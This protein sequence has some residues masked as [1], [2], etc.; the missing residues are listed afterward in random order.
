MF[1]TLHQIFRCWA[2]Y[3]KSWRIIVLPFLLLLYNV[4]TVIMMTYWNVT[5]PGAVSTSFG[6]RLQG[7]QG[8]YFASTILI[9]IYSTCVW[10]NFAFH[11]LILSKFE[12]AIIVKIWRNTLSRHL[13]RFTIRVV[14]ESGLLY[15]ISSIVTFCMV[16]L[17]TPGSIMIA[18]AI[19]RCQRF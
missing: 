9:N 16:F 1:L 10:D 4:S 3:N 5:A 8:S 17:P 2:V 12:A 13:C 7:I 11:I 19:V 14:A 15:A 6:H 18:S